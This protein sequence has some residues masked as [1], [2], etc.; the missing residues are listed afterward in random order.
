MNKFNVIGSEDFNFKVIKESLVDVLLMSVFDLISHCTQR[1]FMCGRVC[2]FCSCLPCI[3]TTDES[4]SEEDE[5]HPAVMLVSSEPEYKPSP[6]PHLSRPPSAKPSSYVKIGDAK[7]TPSASLD[8]GLSANLSKTSVSQAS[9]QPPGTATH[10][11]V[12]V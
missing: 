2:Y 6:A 4:G 1:I 7:A 11:K 10:M 5:D 9:K 12:D 8:V 3:Q